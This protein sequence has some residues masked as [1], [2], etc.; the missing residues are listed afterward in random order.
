MSAEQVQR[1][2]T[3]EA[4]LKGAITRLRKSLESG[5]PDIRQHAREQLAELGLLDQQTQVGYQDPGVVHE[6]DAEV[7]EILAEPHDQRNYPELLA[8]IRHQ[9][10]HTRKLYNE[11][12]TDSERGV[13]QRRINMLLKAER[14]V[15]AAEKIKPELRT[16][17]CIESPQALIRGNDTGL[18]TFQFSK[19]TYS[20]SDPLV[21]AR[22]LDY[23]QDKHPSDPPIMEIHPQDVAL[24]S[25]ETGQFVSWANGL[26]ADESIRNSQMPIRRAR[27]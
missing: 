26:T 16:F 25:D 11:A 3:P 12:L 4:Q 9:L 2:H 10:E 1:M 22:L 17:G 14:L 23:M 18:P 24:V 19:F 6:E 21:I 13:R 20:T 7:L 8:N 27:R 5:D 15:L